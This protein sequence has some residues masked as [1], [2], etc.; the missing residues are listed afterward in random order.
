MSDEI[1]QMMARLKLKRAP[2]FVS[3]YVEKC[4]IVAI[5]IALSTSLE[6]SLYNK[7]VAVILFNQNFNLL[8]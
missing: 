2:V 7:A 8:H 1:E 4:R 3:R 5:G 6:N